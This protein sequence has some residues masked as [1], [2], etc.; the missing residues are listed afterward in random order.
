MRY[1]DV[2]LPKNYLRVCYGNL[3]HMVF[4]ELLL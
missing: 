1:K 2:F 3:I 4:T